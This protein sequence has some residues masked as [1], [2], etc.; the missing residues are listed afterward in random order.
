MFLSP[1][2]EVSDDIPK[3]HGLF[4]TEEV[5]Y[6]TPNEKNALWALAGHRFCKRFMFRNG[7]D[8][9]LTFDS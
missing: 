6:L 7:Y 1:Y 9:G 2:P 4:K 5:S 8:L 3:L